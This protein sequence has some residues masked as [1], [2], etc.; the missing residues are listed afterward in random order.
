MSFSPPVVLP[1]L[2]IDS[3]TV[4]CWENLNTSLPVAK[5]KA[6][7]LAGVSC[8]PILLPRSQH[9]PC[10]L[11]AGDAEGKQVSE[12]TEHHI[13]GSMWERTGLND[14]GKT[15]T[16]A[17]ASGTRGTFFRGAVARDCHVRSQG[18]M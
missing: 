13:Q 15:S 8:K 3:V 1:L 16:F 9:K 6:T 14:N 12:L 11:Q 5:L 17:E 7:L 18:V 4:H 10:Y 2:T